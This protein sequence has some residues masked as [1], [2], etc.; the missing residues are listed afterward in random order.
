VVRKSQQ[1]PSSDYPDATC[2][3]EHNLDR[4]E[5]RNGP[6][7]HSHRDLED[8]FAPSNLD[9]SNHEPLHLSGPVSHGVALRHDNH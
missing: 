3:S 7:N 9:G 8:P 2:H 4:E 1:V 6:L 5:Q